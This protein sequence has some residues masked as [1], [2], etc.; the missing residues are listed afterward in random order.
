MR[1]LT[2]TVA[3]RC[4]LD[5]RRSENQLTEQERPSE[6]EVTDR[7]FTAVGLIPTMGALHQG[8][9]SL[10]QRARQENATVIVSIFV[11]PLQFAPNEDFHRYPRTLDQ[12][13]Q[14]CEQA[15]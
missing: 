4:Y 12:D 13:L 8:H 10:I 2:T 7:H 14:L 9:L 11:N 3:L 6:F 1:L 15:G 5:Q